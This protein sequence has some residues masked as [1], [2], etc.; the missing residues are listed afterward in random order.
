MDT[1][2]KEFIFD[3]RYK[4]YRHIL[5]WVVLYIDELFSLV[6]LTSE[7]EFPQL[8]IVQLIL[9]I[10]TVYIAL[11]LFIPRF[12]NTR[13]Y[14][15]F[16]F[17]VFVSVLF[18]IQLYLI[19]ENYYYYYEEDHLSIYITSFVSTI[20]I[21]GLA[22]AI[23]L[24]KQQVR[25]TEERQ[26][27]IEQKNKI[28]LQ[29][30]KDQINPH[31]LFNVLNT[32]Y[33]QTQTDAS[34]ATESI[35]KLSDLL[36]FQIYDVAHKEW[37]SYNQETTFLKNYLDLEIMRRDGLRYD[38]A[39]QS[40]G[41]SS[42]T[43]PSFTYLPII[44]NAIKHSKTTMA[45]DEF[46]NIQVSKSD[47]HLLLNCSNNIGD[48]KHPE[49]GFGLDNLKKRLNLLF[50]SQHKLEIEKKGGIFSIELSLPLNELHNNR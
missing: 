17:L 40:E 5:F 34:A 26:H 12:L 15:L 49:G 28:E 46:I 31:F 3:S 6:G 35:M 36:R 7:M 1:F 42:L 32:I 43:I 25:Q 9:D 50:N 44:E 11:Y 39:E 20:S 2:I 27:L 33:I 24:L 13:Q 23:K 19:A 37:I 30:L 8:I 14:G 38:W 22:I 18:N 48:I 21:I 16:L 10:L 4:P 45:S 41:L 47:T 29:S